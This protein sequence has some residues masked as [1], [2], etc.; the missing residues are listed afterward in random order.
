MCD[1]VKHIFPHQALLLPILH[2]SNT[3]LLIIAAPATQLTA[4]VGAS[5]QQVFHLCIVVLI[6]FVLA[7]SCSVLEPFKHD[8]GR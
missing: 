5:L 8:A 4:S 2:M 7:E 1:V 6:C 3:H